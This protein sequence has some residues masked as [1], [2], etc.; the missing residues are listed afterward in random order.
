MN[1]YESCTTNGNIVVN[2]MFQSARNAV[3]C[4]FG[5]LKG[6]IEHSYTSYG[7]EDRACTICC[8]FMLCIAQFL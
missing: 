2:S 8:L 3:E 5:R 7:S 1:E 6:K 4:A